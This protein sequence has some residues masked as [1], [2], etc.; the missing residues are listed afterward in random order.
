[1]FHRRGRF[2]V[3]AGGV[4]LRD[5]RLH[6]MKE[7]KSTKYYLT[8]IVEMVLGSRLVIYNRRIDI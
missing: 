3:T 1:M 8:L 7:P 4:T 5:W 2:F 6:P